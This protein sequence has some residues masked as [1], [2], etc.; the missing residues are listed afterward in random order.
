MPSRISISEFEKMIEKVSTVP[1]PDA[2]FIESLRARFVLDGHLGAIKNQ[3]KKVN[4]RISPPRFVWVVVV[5][6]CVAIAPL[7]SSPKVATALR[8]LLGYVPGVGTVE[9]TSSL[10]ILT[11]PVKVTREAVTVTVEQAVLSNEKTVIVYSYHT[12]A[13]DSVLP[14]RT[15]DERMPSLLLPNGTRLIIKSGHQLSKVDCLE[16]SMRYRMEFEAIPSDI[17]E[18]T[19]ELP[20]LIEAPVGSAP[21]DWQIPLKFRTAD[22]NELLPVNEVHPTIIPSLISETA[23][24]IQTASTY[25]VSI[26]LNRSVKLD[27]GY[28]LYG[29]T[30]W[31]DPIIPQYRLSSSLASIKDSNGSEISFDYAPGDGLSPQPGEL[32]Y[33][34]SYKLNTSNLSGPVSLDFVLDAWVSSNAT[35]AFDPGQNQQIG[36]TWDLNVDMHINEHMV[37]VISAEY[38]GNGQFTFLMKADPGVVGAEL[39]DLQH[40]PLFGGGGGGLPED[41]VIFVS[42]LYYGDP[43]PPGPLTITISALNVLIPGDWQIEWTPEK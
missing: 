8:K 43:I 35:F 37:H 4:P 17:I 26:S 30:R 24:P 1:E 42:S 12:P 41:Q 20:S 28:I 22:T 15:M 34:W 36:Q 33:Y 5:I 10:R 39:I 13:S 21:Q 3:E 25:G 40:P 16:C 32:V 29:S 9:H 2:A 7:L 19:L 14:E 18:V 11:E 38:G 31:S 6:F 27:D 23:Q